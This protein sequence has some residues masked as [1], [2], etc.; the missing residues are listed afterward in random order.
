[1]TTPSEKASHRLAR[2]R[3]VA[4]GNQW[5]R[6]NN[7]RFE[8]E[9]AKMEAAHAALAREVRPQPRG[10]LRRALDWMMT[11]TPAGQSE[12]GNAKE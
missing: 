2:V 7:E 12:A 11:P 8:A 4:A 1:M 10:L 6:E 9:F 3:L 5:R